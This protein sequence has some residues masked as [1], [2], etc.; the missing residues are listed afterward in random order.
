MVRLGIDFGTTN[1]VVS[2]CDRG[3][4][5]VVDLSVED[6]ARLSLP[7]VVAYRTPAEGEAPGEILCGQ[8]AL[9][10]L[11]K[12][13]YQVLLSP[14]RLLG[15]PEPELPPA[16][17]TG[18]QPLLERLLDAQVS[19]LKELLLSVPGVD[20]ATELQVVLGIPANANSLQRYRTLEAFR[21]G[22]FEV[23]ELVHEP[24][25]A[26]IEY[27][28]LHPRF[29]RDQPRHVLVYDLGGGTFDVSV[30]RVET[31]Q[32]RVLASGGVEQLGGADFDR[33][34]LDLALEKVGLDASKV[35]RG[36]LP[37][38]LRRCCEVKESLQGS[39]KKLYV[40]L[41][42][43]G[44]EDVAVYVEDY[45][46]R[47]A[48]LI[49]RTLQATQEVLAAAGTLE[50]AGLDALL[51]VGGG[52]Q[53]PLVR[54]RL[55]SI[56]G[57]RL[58]ISPHPFASTAVGLAIHADQRASRPVFDR[59]S[60]H[61]GVWREAAAG[62]LPRFDLIF[63]KDTA[64]PP[65]G[66]TLEVVRSYQPHHNI[67]FF[68]FEECGAV[69]DDARRTEESTPW[70]RILF[71]FDPALGANDP[72]LDREVVRTTRFAETRITERYCCDSH[73]II[74]VEISRDNP[75]LERRYMLYR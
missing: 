29:I 37:L 10:V 43:L 50:M 12:D 73:G 18:V 60:R 34:L 36:L 35:S 40:V 57:S 41:D 53:L 28:H 9:D 45:Y 70:N 61:F 27:A 47:C 16:S 74:T 66:E 14:K 8:A 63:A 46:A 2:L 58:K 30:V 26:A 11:G 19:E 25:A 6:A 17:S 22:G 68:R 56:V 69:S 55:R 32:I 52:A 31:E 72:L 39:T 20:W 54:R 71:P 1:I 13:D 59:F 75:P 62:T 24:T 64:L 7:S 42:E 3:N 4:Y 51:L 49:E 65:R 21:R 5:P 67:G 44:H 23:I 48:P 15:T 33:I 38:L